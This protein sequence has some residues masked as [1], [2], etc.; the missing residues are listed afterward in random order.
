[1]QSKQT[2]DEEQ[3][4]IDDREIEQRKSGSSRIIHEVIRKE[5]EEELARPALSLMFSGLVAG[6]AI[7]AS[8]LGKTFLRAGLPDAP[9]RH[10]V[11][12]LG[13]TLG[14]IIVIMA[15]LQLFTES[16]VTA[17]LPVANDLRLAKLVALLRLWGIVLAANMA[18]TLL[19]SA[20]FVSGVILSPD[21][22]AAMADISRGLLAHDVFHTL[23]LGIP[24][25]FLVGSIAWILPNGRES[26]IWVII[27]LTYLVGVGDF[28]HVVAGSGEA[29]FLWLDGLASLG[30]V[31]GGILLPSLVGNI[32]GGSALFA[33]LAHAQVRGELDGD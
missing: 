15:R 16:T 2:K 26:Q 23:M 27:F 10:L 33:I 32:I 14:F 20:L 17:V 18:G 1:M 12:S 22:L 25:G 4:S 3:I 29:W 6:F 7:N 30:H 8:L 9:W 13:Y 24:S 5:G 19:A 21:D 28:T 31:I 11:E